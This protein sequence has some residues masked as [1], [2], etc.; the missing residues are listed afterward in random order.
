MPDSITLEEFLR[1]DKYGR[2]ALSA[3]RNP[4]TCGLSGKTYSAPDVVA[5]TDSLARAIGKRL[6]FDPLDGTEWDRVVGL[7][8]LNTVSRPFELKCPLLGE[9]GGVA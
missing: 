3:S 2:R 6:S 4:Y 5:R 9:R 8:S 1:D 7:F